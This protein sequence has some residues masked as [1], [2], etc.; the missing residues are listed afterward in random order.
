M[1]N[2]KHM[3]KKK[4]QL[5]LSTT[6]LIYN[7]CF[8]AANFLFVFLESIGVSAGQ[9]GL[10]SACVSGIGIASQPTW[11]VISDRIQSVK[12]CFM[13]C[14]VGTALC[15][16]TIPALSQGTGLWR[17]LMIGMLMAMYFFFH[18][19]N[20]MMELWLVR[21]SDN[22]LL[23]IPYGTIRSCAS[24][25]Y[26]LFSLAFVP[27]V[28]IMPVR[29]IYYFFSSFA[30]LSILLTAMVP[31]ESE[32]KTERQAKTRLRDMPFRSI[33]N[34]WIVGHIIFEVLYQIPFS[35]R[36]TY[37]VY[38]L[39]EFQVD[40]SMYGALMFVAGICEVPMLLL[41]KRFTPRT[42]WAW[43]MLANVLILTLEYSLYALGHSVFVLFAAQ[44]LRGFSYALYVA[45]R[46]QY[47]HR[48]APKGMEGSTI[49]LVNTSTAVMNL[50]AA[51]AGG[52]LLEAL[53][54][55]SF[56]ALL[57][58][59]QLLSGIFFVGLHVVGVKYLH[60]PPQN[61]ECM[62]TLNPARNHGSA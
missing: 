53:G 39:K 5:Q 40:T 8:A 13:L 21:V 26:A 47:L 9:M 17:L 46:Y 23:K 56:F 57:C 37:M 45:S 41:I 2:A 29:N 48:L 52:F 18:P 33:L 28:Q 38:T 12:K 42:G 32:G 54:T 35:W 1:G 30:A 34:Y 14:M 59:L 16:L 20:M 31:A 24:I 51:T 4:V 15:A 36:V 10:I 6:E 55:R 49:A 60:H 25:G 11:G 22:P 7:G 27:I 61:R 50:I 44:L 3:N 58:G 19:S 62:L 43:P